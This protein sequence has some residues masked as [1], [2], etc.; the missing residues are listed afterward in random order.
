MKTA[1][2]RP[3]TRGSDDRLRVG[4]SLLIV[5]GLL[6]LAGA[7]AAWLAASSNSHLVRN[8]SLVRMEQATYIAEGG[9][10][11]GAS[12]LAAN[13]GVPETLRGNLGAGRYVAMVLSENLDAGVV[14]SLSGRINI[15]PG[16]NTNFAFY[17][18]RPDGSR[19]SHRELLQSV[20]DYNGPAVLVGVQPTGSGLQNQ[21]RVRGLTYTITNL[22]TYGFRSTNMNVRIW[23]DGRTADGRAAGLWWIEFSSTNASTTSAGDPR[24][25]RRSTSFTI[26]STGYVQNQVRPVTVRGVTSLRWSRYA[27]WYDQ[28]AMQIWFTGGEQFRGLVYSRPTM[29]FH[30][31]RVREDGQTLFTE[32]VLTCATN[33]VVEN[34]TVRP[35]FQ[36]GITF[37]APTQNLSSINLSLLRDEADLVFTGTTYVVLAS[38]LMYVTNA[39][40]L[41]TNRAVTITN[42]NLVYIATADSGDTASRPGHLYISSVTGMSGRIAFIADQNIYF[43]N[44]VRLSRNPAVY[45]DSRDLLGLIAATNAVVTTN[46]PNNLEIFAHIICK[47]GGFG[48]A[49]YNNSRLGSRGTLTVYGGV[50]NLILNPVGTSEGLGYRRNYSFD[51]RLKNHTPPRYPSIPDIFTW[52]DWDG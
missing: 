41:W 14:G 39:R 29:R 33:Y 46:A 36:R 35:N 47:D 40:R 1:P 21:L 5:M 20:P 27:L 15:N 51:V 6:F 25:L 24:P 42:E 50:V 37:R 34:S 43:T 52:Q 3:D 9:V 17:A 26:F 19:I 28:E 16:N 12:H 22:Y 8:R 32:R 7:L 11:R 49:E 48:V 13:G 2:G 23:N 4:A 31:Y 30:S 18:E 10:E 45:P 38:N 44:H